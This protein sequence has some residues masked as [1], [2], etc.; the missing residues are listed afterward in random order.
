MLPNNFESL[1]N[2]LPEH[3]LEVLKIG[4]WA[5]RHTD[6]SFL[7]PR[8]LSRDIRDVDPFR[9][10][11]ALYRLVDAGMYR[12]VY[13]VVTPEG[14]FAENEYD[15]PLDVPNLPL[16]GFNHPFRIEDGDIVPVFT[17]VR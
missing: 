12:Q 11:L 9:I 2:Q 14:V 3:R 7:D 6:W 13:K 8:I 16:D 1:A 10:V 5:R 15:T 4:D 17:P